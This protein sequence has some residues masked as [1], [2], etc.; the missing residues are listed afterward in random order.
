MYAASH[1][2]HAAAIIGL[3]DGSQPF[4]RWLK[5]YFRQHKKFGSRDRK[6]V[7]H[8]CYCYFR[9]GR[10]FT[11]LPVKE[12]IITGLFLCSDEA[13]PLLQ[14]LNPDWNR[15]A[16]LSLPEKMSLLQA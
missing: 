3:Y 8:L 5:D 14:E 13:S 4:A 15:H 16:G 10:A 12:K 2:Q 6:L 7:G 11:L 9:L 1:V